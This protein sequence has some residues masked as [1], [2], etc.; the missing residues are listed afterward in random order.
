MTYS[1][2][3]RDLDNYKSGLHRFLCENV[4]GFSHLTVCTIEDYPDRSFYLLYDLATFLGL[5]NPYPQIKATVNTEF[6]LRYHPFES[7]SSIFLSEEGLIQFV[8]RCRK[9]SAKALATAI[10]KYTVSQ[11]L[12]DL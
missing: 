2:F 9:P 4:S 10:V 5:V 6:V 3:D 12:N 1:C 8:L 11:S 7:K